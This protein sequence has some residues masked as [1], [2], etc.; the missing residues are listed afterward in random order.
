M[1][2]ILFLLVILPTFCFAQKYEKLSDEQIDSLFVEMK[3]D[4]K[5]T[6]TGWE[7]QKIIEVKADKN[8]IYNRIVDALANIYNDSKDVIQEKNKE[9]GIIIAKGFTDSKWREVNWATVVRNRCWHIIKIEI[10]DGK[11]RITLKVN[12]VEYENGTNLKFGKEYPLTGM[13][14]YWSECKKKHRWHSFNNLRFVYD[15]SISVMKEI[16]D[17]VKKE[18]SNDDW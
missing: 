12:G 6:D 16:E 18:S 15:S 11:Y 14:P 8:D 13:W 17:Y 7:F 2:K 1:K 10:K 3:K 4:F 5:E 9:D